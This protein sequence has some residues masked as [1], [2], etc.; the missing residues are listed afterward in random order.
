MPKAAEYRYPCE[1]CGSALTF[2]PGQKQLVCPYCGHRQAIPPDPTAHT[3]PVDPAP[4][5]DRI[6]A[7]DRRMWD[8]HGRPLQWEAGRK[9]QGLVEIDLARGLAMDLPSEAVEDVRMLSCPNC[10]AKV[11]ID[12]PTH[13]TD[14]PFCATPVVMDTGATR[15]IKP[16][17]V[18]PFR[19]TE[20]EARA[21]LGKWLGRLWFA[22]SDVVQYTRKGRAMTGIYSPFWTFDADTASAYRGLRG[23]TYY[24][25]EWVTVMVDG[26]AQRQ[27]QQVRKIRWTP[28][29]GRVARRFNDVLVLAAQSLPKTHTDALTP[30]DLAEVVP[31]RPDYL[32]GFQAEGYTVPLVDGH[33]YAREEM[34]HV[35]AM[36]VRRDIGGDEQRIEVIDTRHADETFKHILL[37]I[38]T[39][40]YKYN[41]KSYRF[42]V[43]GQS[44]RVQ[45][46]RPYSPWKI[47]LAVI[48][49]MILFAALFLV[50]Q[51]SQGSGGGVVI[52]GFGSG[53]GSIVIDPDFGFG[54]NGGPGGGRIITIPG[55]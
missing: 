22:P 55:Y 40:A 32:S 54:S 2:Q 41:G 37:P 20:A 12:G 15:Q 18:I 34:A 21:E 8:D 31:Y 4:P 33:R 24:E 23:D 26:R 27:Q 42:V 5:E 39:A 14:C 51:N 9:F 38:W 19:L 16:Q 36:D 7:F 53:G 28:A 10:G 3:V 48:A 44:G 11:E 30:W 52:P 46:E 6:G 1:S 25:T 17:G 49:A 47:A 50:M 43:N 35:I 13:A 29:G 45:G